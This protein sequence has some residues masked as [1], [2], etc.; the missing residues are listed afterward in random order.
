[1]G[2]IDE[3]TESQKSRDTVPLRWDKGSNRFLFEELIPSGLIFPVGNI[4]LLSWKRKRAERLKR[5]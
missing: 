3:K 5:D 1:M 4:V 2:L